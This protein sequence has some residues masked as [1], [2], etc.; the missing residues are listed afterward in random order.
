MCI[1]KIKTKNLDCKANTHPNPRQNLCLPIGATI[2]AVARLI[3]FCTNHKKQRC[4]LTTPRVIL[5]WKTIEDNGCCPLSF[6]LVDQVL[7]PTGLPM[8]SK[9]NWILQTPLQR[10]WVPMIYAF[11]PSTLCLLP[12]QMARVI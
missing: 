6:L 3:H 4:P 10:C 9:F 11:K 5:N 8:Q 12:T 1:G 2:G 7:R